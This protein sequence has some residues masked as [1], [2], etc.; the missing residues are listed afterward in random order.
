MDET[1]RGTRRKRGQEE[2][3]DNKQQ[4]DITSQLRKEKIVIAILFLHSL[5][6]GFV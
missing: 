1:T 4:F 2:K 5:Y 3:G 6:C